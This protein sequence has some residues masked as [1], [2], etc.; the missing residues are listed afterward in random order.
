[1]A[2]SKTDIE[3]QELPSIDDVIDYARYVRRDLNFDGTDYSGFSSY[4]RYPV[5]SLELIDV[6]NNDLTPAGPDGRNPS[7]PREAATMTGKP[8]AVHFREIPIPESITS[9]FRKHLSPCCFS[10]DS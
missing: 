7:Q 2:I 9:K 8:G 1:M 10:S 6:S 3:K 4:D 5:E